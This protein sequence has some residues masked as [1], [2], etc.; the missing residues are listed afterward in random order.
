MIA[1]SRICGLHSPLISNQAFAAFLS[2]RDNYESPSFL[3]NILKMDEVH[4]RRS[5]RL[6]S[7]RRKVPSGRGSFMK[8]NIII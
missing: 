5:T 1:D 2:A 3:K 6:G 7:T 8:K 4:T